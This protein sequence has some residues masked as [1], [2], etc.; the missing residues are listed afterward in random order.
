LFF[1]EEAGPKGCVNQVFNVGGLRKLAPPALSIVGFLEVLCEV[2]ID[3]FSSD[4][5]GGI[6]FRHIFLREC[7]V[8]KEMD[9]IHLGALLNA[10]L[11][12]LTGLVLFGAAFIV[13]DKLIPLNLWKEIGENRNLALATLLAGLSIAL[14]LIISSAVH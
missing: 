13:I 9:D 8:G 14:A 12:A 10:V 11:F 7:T 1:P 4:A 6:A 2:G 5:S 3:G